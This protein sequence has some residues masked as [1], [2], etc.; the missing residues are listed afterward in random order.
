MLKTQECSTKWR[1]IQSLTQENQ[2][3]PPPLMFKSL[4]GMIQKPNPAPNRNSPATAQ[5]WQGPPPL[6]LKINT[7]ASVQAAKNL[8][9][10]SAVIRDSS[11]SVVSC[12]VF[13]AHGVVDVDAAEALAVRLGMQLSASVPYSEFIVESDSTS[14]I[15]RLHH[16]EDAIDPVQTIV[17]EC[18][19]LVGDRSICFQHIPRVCNQVA[20]ALAKWGVFFGGDCLF[21]GEVPFPVYELVNSIG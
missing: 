20:R 14:I 11:G 17:D 8:S 21:T 7:D 3:L 10:A 12:G 19:A 15:R 4:Y 16:P 1:Y 13:V 2:R 18:L 5:L 6:V 9:V